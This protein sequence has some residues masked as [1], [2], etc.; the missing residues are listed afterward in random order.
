MTVT[1]K[2]IGTDDGKFNVD[3]PTDSTEVGAALTDIF[4]TNATQDDVNTVVE[5]DTAASDT[6]TTQE[7]ENSSAMTLI[8]SF[9]ASLI[10]FVI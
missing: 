3:L 1:K 9:V 5:E 8:V 6:E 4:S 7:N 2:N 10:A